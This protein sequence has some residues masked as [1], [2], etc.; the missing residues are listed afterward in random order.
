MKSLAAVALGGALGA[1]ARYLSISASAHFFGHQFP[2]GTLLVN[3]IGS[4]IM[5]ILVETMALVWTAGVETR[6]FLLVGVLGAFTTFSS[7]SLDVAV[8]FERG[9]VLATAMYITFSVV[10][11]IAALFAGMVLIR[12][13]LID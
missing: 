1:T 11:S 3:I 8:L 10:L 13:L 2:Y 5:G 12:R 6:L 7:F 9:R 4:F